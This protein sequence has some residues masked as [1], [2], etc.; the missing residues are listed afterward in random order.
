[1][2]HLVASQ[3]N[4]DTK[5]RATNVCRNFQNF[6]SLM[7]K[8]LSSMGWFSIS[9]VSKIRLL[10]YTWKTRSFAVMFVKED[11]KV[12]RV[13]QSHNG[14][15]TM[16]WRI[17][18]MGP[19]SCK[20]LSDDICSPWGMQ[21]LGRLC[22][23]YVSEGCWRLFRSADTLPILAPRTFLHGCNE[24]SATY[25]AVKRKLDDLHATTQ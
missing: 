16:P 5:T 24:R 12:C 7:I 13:S 18:W 9:Q 2:S 3:L 1:M 20:L 14:G 17:C 11:L 19:W 25:A 8:Q 21:G 10:D 15:T 22:W 23:L 4:Q 6:Q